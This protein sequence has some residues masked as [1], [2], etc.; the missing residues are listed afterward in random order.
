MDIDDFKNDLLSLDPVEVVRKDII[1]GSPHAVDINKYYLLRR[2][3]SKE[4]DIHPSEVLLVGSGMLGFSIVPDKRYRAFCDESDLDIV[5][6][7]PSLFDRMW[8]AVNSYR[9]QGGLWPKEYRDDFS[10]Y[11]L[12][13][14]IRPDKFPPEASFPLKHK[15]F[16]FF[17]ALSNSGVYGPYKI[18]AGIYRSWSFLEDYQTICIESCKQQLE[19]TNENDSD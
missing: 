2:D 19:V 14:W 9:R 5:I 7:A 18:A 3:V 12:R 17:A 4:Y 15:W 1:F 16:E 10:K 8:S 13:G 11:L 6:L